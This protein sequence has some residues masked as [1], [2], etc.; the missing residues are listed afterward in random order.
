MNFGLIFELMKKDWADG[1]KSK[2]IFIFV[3]GFPLFLIVILPGVLVGAMSAIPELMLLN[4]ST[5]VLLN[6]LPAVT[7]DWGSLSESARLTV[8]TAVLGQI[9]ILLVPVMVSSIVSADS[10][11]GE[12][13]RKTIE[14]LLALPMTD[15]EIVIAKIL[16]GM[17]PAL[18]STWIFTGIH[19]IVIDIIAFPLLQRLLLPDLRFLVLTL[20]FT[21]L[22]AFVTVTF[23]VMISSRVSTSRDAQQMTGFLVLPLLILILS[24]LYLVLLDISLVIVG[25]A[26]LILAAVIFFYLGEKT[27]NREKIMTSR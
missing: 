7:P 19:I 6:F 20:L 9:F 12:K 16:S 26:I 18:F 8:F 23:T 4:P 17:L 10:V 22:L 3:V 21:P 15:R 27:F 24:Q 25:T 14:V 11:V 5:A 1:F 2:Q 13:E